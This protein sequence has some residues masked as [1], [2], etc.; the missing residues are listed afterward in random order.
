MDCF[1]YYELIRI[2]WI[3]P[4]IVYWPVDCGLI[5]IL[6]ID[7]RIL[8]WTTQCGLSHRKWMNQKYLYHVPL[9]HPVISILPLIPN[10]N[11]WMQTWNSAR[12]CEQCSQKIFIKVR[13][14]LWKWMRKKVGI[15]ELD[16]EGC[17]FKCIHSFWMIHTLWLFPEIVDW[18][19]NC[20]SNHG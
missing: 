6:R 8:D 18:S 9:D 2:L 17:G 11:I 1:T 12:A 13:K 3:D 19:T 16:V 10:V 20:R 4:R 7:P 5:H 15:S 14:V